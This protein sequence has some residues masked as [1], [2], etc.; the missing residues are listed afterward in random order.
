MSR[1]RDRLRI[2]FATLVT[3]LACGPLAIAQSET[4]VVGV[5]S[6]AAGDPVPEYRVIARIA[7]GTTVFVSP[8][9]DSEGR[10]SLGVP[11]GAEYILVA[12]ISPTGERVELQDLPP[13][14]VGSTEVAR[15]ITIPAVPPDPHGAIKTRAHVDRFF[16]LFV[17][18]P[19]LVR[20]RHYEVQFV[21]EHFDDRDRAVLRG[22]GAFQ[23][24][25]LPRV[26]I[27]ASLGF[28]DLDTALFGGGSG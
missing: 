14:A 20:Y 12:L 18:D 17:E 11:V 3:L 25:S 15:N 5:I 9:S 23:F 7:E 16:L 8:P 4:R 19:S 2:A 21:R 10:Y 28:A 22:I 27:G 6:D 1:E 13:V 26:E 24:K